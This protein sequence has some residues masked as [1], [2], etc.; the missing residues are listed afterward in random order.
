MNRT[1]YCPGLKD[2][3]L[4]QVPDKIDTEDIPGDDYEEVLRASMEKLGSV[5]PK[6]IGGFSSTLT[7]KNLEVRAGLQL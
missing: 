6:V 3:S 2:I 1:D 7:W 4:N 5:N